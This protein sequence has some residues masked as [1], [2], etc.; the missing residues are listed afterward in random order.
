MGWHEL[1]STLQR[2]RQDQVAV[3]LNFQVEVLSWLMMKRCWSFGMCPIQ[4]PRGNKLEFGKFRREKGNQNTGQG[5]ATKSKLL[6]YL[7][8]LGAYEEV[9]GAVLWGVDHQRAVG[10]Q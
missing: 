7:L 3:N 9:G 1:R 5:L 2:E 10:G 4:C 8:M 6:P